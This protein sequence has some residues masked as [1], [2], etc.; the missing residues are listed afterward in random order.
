MSLAY[1]LCQ[2]RNLSH[3]NYTLSKI[4]HLLNRFSLSLQGGSSPPIVCLAAI[5]GLRDAR[6]SVFLEFYTTCSFIPVLSL[7][8]TFHSH[9]SLQTGDADL[10]ALLGRGMEEDDR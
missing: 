5:L 8:F 6:S 1:S 4:T 3:Q 9:V 2:W 10:S 7:I